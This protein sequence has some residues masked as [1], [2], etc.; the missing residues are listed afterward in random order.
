MKT[1][2]LIDGHAVDQPLYG[3]EKEGLKERLAHINSLLIET[4]SHLDQIATSLVGP[5]PKDGVG[6]VKDSCISVDSLTDE[7]IKNADDI[8]KKI[9][10]TEQFLSGNNQ[11]EYK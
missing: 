5:V 9:R 3:G 2:N 1:Y 7:I 6:C 10:G 4:N 11:T 8:A